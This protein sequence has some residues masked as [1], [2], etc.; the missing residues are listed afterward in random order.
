MMRG[1]GRGDS[2]NKLRAGPVSG[3]RPL[4]GSWR[5]PNLKSYPPVRQAPLSCFLGLNQQTE[6]SQIIDNRRLQTIH[7]NELFEWTPAS[8][9][10]SLPTAAIQGSALLAGPLFYRGPRSAAR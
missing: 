6:G 5:Q 7:L 10:G 3:R 2:W 4:I 8:E 1:S 9:S